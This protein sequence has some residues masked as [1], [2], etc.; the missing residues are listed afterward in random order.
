MEL[1][2]TT[3]LIGITAITSILAF[4]RH[5]MLDRWMFMPYRIRHRGEWDRFIL[6]GFIHKDYVHLLFNMFTFYFFGRV[7]ELFLGY[8]FGPLVGGILFIAFYLLGIII[9]DIPTYRKHQDDSYY[10]ALG[11]SGGTSATVFA[12]IVIMPLSDICLFGI[13]CLPGF[14]LGIL[15]LIYSY[16]QGK[17]GQDNINH[18]AHLYGAIFGIVSILIISPNSGLRFVEQIKNFSLF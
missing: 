3:V 14:I 2:L 9:S 4:N 12:S 18:D 7:V 13:I 16:Y 11:A 8:T 6:S 1:S 10:R 17:K 15:F 5:E